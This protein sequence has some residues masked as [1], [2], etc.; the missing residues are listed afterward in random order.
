MNRQCVDVIIIGGGVIGTAIAYYLVKE[1][2]EVTLIE[3][4]DIASGTSGACD[5]NL[6][7]LSKSPGP[8]FNLAR[9]SLKLF[10]SLVKNLDHNVQYRKNGS[11]IILETKEQWDLS[12]KNI[13][14]QQEAGLNV[15]LM[16]NKQTRNIEPFLTSDIYG[17]C[18][19]E[20]NGHINPIMLTL[21]LGKKSLQQ[22]AHILLHEPVK[23]ILWKKE[24]VLGVRTTHRDIYAKYIVNAAGVYANEIGKMAE[25][26]IPVIPKRGQ[27]LVTESIPSFINNSIICGCYLKAKYHLCDKK[28]I[29]DPIVSLGRGLSLEQTIEGNL[30]IGS[31]REY[32]NFNTQTTYEGITAI[33][34]HACQLFPKLKEVKMIRSFSG[35]RPAT[36]DGLPIIGH[37]EALKG[38][39]LAVGHEGDG[40]I[41]APIT[42]K[43]I[44]ELICGKSLSVNIQPFSLE[45]F[46]A[47]SGKQDQ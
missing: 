46:K 11:L 21:G 26:N 35:L 14:K 36:I 30:L 31:T 38:M 19:T 10:P 45:R 18:Y 37:S 1:G 8:H 3:K 6:M 7:L 16:D 13:K 2:V 40:I 41:L 28:D 15:R 23:E 39:L 4:E 22:G 27:I 24:Q 34:Q 12:Q 32:V 9:E 20:E 33:A 42:G 29:S 44:A 17:S 47:A 43:L 5:G 25:I